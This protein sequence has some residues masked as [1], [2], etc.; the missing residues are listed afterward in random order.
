MRKQRRSGKEIEKRQIFNEVVNN[1]EGKNQVDCK[2][3]PVVES[4]KGQDVRSENGECNLGFTDYDD[5]RRK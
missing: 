2:S 5:R 4:S 1:T 3:A